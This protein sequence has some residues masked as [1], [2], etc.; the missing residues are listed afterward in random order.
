MQLKTPELFIPGLFEGGPAPIYGVPGVNCSDPYE[1]PP[2]SQVPFWLGAI[3]SA[4]Q[5]EVC[6]LSL[7]SGCAVSL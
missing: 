3:T 7:S 2:A 6:A 1:V 4:P 5:D